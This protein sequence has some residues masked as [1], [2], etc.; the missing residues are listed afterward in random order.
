MSGGAQS[1][2]DVLDPLPEAE[3]LKLSVDD[4]KSS[5]DALARLRDKMLGHLGLRVELEKQ[6]YKD[7]RNR[8]YLVTVLVVLVP[9]LAVGLNTWSLVDARFGQV[10]SALAAFVSAA[11]STVILVAR[12]SS[13]GQQAQLSQSTQLECKS[14][15]EITDSLWRQFVLIHG[16]TYRS[17]KNATA[18]CVWLTH[19]S[20]SLTKAN[21]DL[22][23]FQKD[24][25]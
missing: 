12:I 10:P 25:I 18:L 2:L 21:R 7:Y 24:P 17:Y 6:Q 4:R 8:Y 16:D 14:I 20:A 19:R 23:F 13:F 9:L 11:A 3:W 15:E 1:L 5:L 22:T